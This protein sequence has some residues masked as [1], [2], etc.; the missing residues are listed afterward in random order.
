MTAFS[1]FCNP[2]RRHA[3]RVED[4]DLTG[5]L[6]KYCGL[7]LNQNLPFLDGHERTS[8]KQVTVAD[9]NHGGRRPG[10]R[11]RDFLGIVCYF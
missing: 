9:G 6:Q 11:I 3:T 2:Q 7:V 5:R 4:P 1:H 10:F 8:W